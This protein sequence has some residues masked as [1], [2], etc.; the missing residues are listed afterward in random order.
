[1]ALEE[2]HSKDS[3]EVIA[4]CAQG[5]SETLA[6]CT[7]VERD[8]KA[9]QA[10]LSL[11]VRV[12]QRTVG[13]LSG[14]ARAGAEAGGGAEHAAMLRDVAALGSRVGELEALAT[15]VDANGRQLT[16][17]R[18]VLNASAAGLRTLLDDRDNRDNRD[19]NP[20]HQPRQAYRPPALYPPEEDGDEN[21]AVT[22]E[23]DEGG[24]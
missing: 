7:A 20:E 4:K 18:T 21:G 5:C 22:S 15:V 24:A 2:T 9:G 17:L 12:L 6:K 13:T 23:D 1:M 19:T 16:L 11:Q 14:G 3:S 8:A 10:S